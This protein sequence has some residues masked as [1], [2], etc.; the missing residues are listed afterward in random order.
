MKS[1]KIILKR[2]LKNSRKITNSN[3]VVARTRKFL[4]RNNK[5]KKQ[6]GGIFIKL[7][8]GDIKSDQYLGLID[9]RNHKYVEV[10][11]FP[12]NAMF[13]QY[14]CNN[15][16]I[17]FN[18]KG[19]LFIT[20]KLEE[21]ENNFNLIVT[22]SS[23][24][25]K[26]LEENPRQKFIDVFEDE[27]TT[28]TVNGNT[29]S[30]IVKRTDSSPANPL[31]Y[32]PPSK[33]VPFV[34]TD[35]ITYANELLESIN[36]TSKLFDNLKHQDYN[37][38]VNYT[39]EHGDF[40]I[41]GYP[42]PKHMNPLLSN[43]K[44][45]SEYNTIAEY[46]K[47]N[48][49][50]WLI[51]LYNKLEGDEI[52]NLTEEE[53]ELYKLFD[54]DIKYLNNYDGLVEYES[55]KEKREELIKGYQ[56]NLN[57]TLKDDKPMLRPN[58]KI[59]Y[60]FFIFIKGSDGKYK[61][62]VYNIKDISSSHTGVLKKVLELIETELPRKFNLLHP[63]DNGTYNNFYSFCEFG[64]MFKIE[65]EYLH[66]TTRIDT[67]AYKYAKSMQLEQLIYSSQLKISD[68]SLM[69]KV[70][71]QYSVKKH[72]IT[73]IVN[74]SSIMTGGT[75]FNIDFTGI[76]IIMCNTI[77]PFNIE[78]YYE[79]DNKY[80]YLLLTPNLSE[81][82]IK[83]LFENLS[84]GKKIHSYKNNSI[85]T[86]LLNLGTSYKIL[87]YKEFI[88][89]NID[90]EYKKFS[91]LS[92]RCFPVIRHKKQYKY[93]FIQQTPKTIKDLFNKSLQL[94]KELNEKSGNNTFF[95]I[96]Q[97]KL[98]NTN[99]QK[100]ILIDNFIC[101]CCSKSK[102]KAPSLSNK[103]VSNN[104]TTIWIFN[105]SSTG[106]RLITIGDLN[107]VSVLKKLFLLLRE[108]KIYDFRTEKIFTHIFAGY[109]LDSLHLKI[110]PKNYYQS[111]SDKEFISQSTELRLYDIETIINF[112]SIHQNYFQ[113]LLNQIP[114][115]SRYS[116]QF[117]E[118][119]EI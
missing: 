9:E 107:N 119:P 10:R 118:P 46:Q 89:G 13:L 16:C 87:K 93:P 96:D 36:D 2:N 69:K 20:N 7:P 53:T 91:I 42:D 50:K 55:N 41:V 83:K 6:R 24:K 77:H 5:T 67:F 106:E 78:I 66:P 92:N 62:L 73:D 18:E 61:F 22:V 59:K 15:E 74:N 14:L 1:Q 112:M 4:K 82:D 72:N 32:V 51:G 12:L 103:E 43:E 114:Y 34:L 108:R 95:S 45:M 31:V 85:Q 76:N 105:K 70:K 100:I 29:L 35:D 44:F 28:T 26:V 90:I 38:D 30:I 21:E 64:E 113:E 39:D 71:L 48:Y 111:V 94:L 68:I 81:L 75:L 56:N 33:R 25:I 54:V 109:T 80:Y 88:K 84:N 116:L 98:N 86:I 19:E 23:Q 115:Y 63:S 97:K 27:T 3:Q 110:Y 40:K 8:N 60:I 58:F 102:K 117:I 17:H 47:E 65:I 104:I 57:K 101:V 11:P 49:H 37:I 79:K 99:I 52:S